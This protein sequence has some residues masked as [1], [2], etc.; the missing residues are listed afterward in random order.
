MIRLVRP[1]AAAE[2]DGARH[3]LAGETTD[4]LRPLAAEAVAGDPRA[5]RTLLVALGPP[6]LRVIRSVLGARRAGAADV[7]DVLQEV[8]LTLYGALPGFR[9]ECKT[10]HFACRIAVQTAMNARRRAGYRNRHTPSVEPEAL[11][12]L[13][14]DDRSPAEVMASTR[15]VAAVRELLGELPP[16]QAEALALH[17]MLGY[18]VAETAAATGAP[19]NTVRSRLRNALGALRERLRDDRALLEAVKDEA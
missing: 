6:L 2:T 18:S 4:P 17:V 5:Q 12:E 16:P 9:G 15:R 7:E 1:P 8:M 14:R 13:A 3:A 19:I 11:S 10:V